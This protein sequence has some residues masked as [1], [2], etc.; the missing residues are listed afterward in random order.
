MSTD[1]LDVASLLHSLHNDI[2]SVSLYT[3]DLTEVLDYHDYSHRPMFLKGLVNRKRIWYD[4]QEIVQMMK[5][6]SE[7]GE[8]NAEFARVSSGL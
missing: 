3:P 2:P 7:S 8:L 1:N 6:L 5:E 4:V